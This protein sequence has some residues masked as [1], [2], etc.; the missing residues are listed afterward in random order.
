MASK[1]Y[2]IPDDC[3]YSSSDEWVR[4][5]G[6]EA[7]I[8]VTD[9][10]QD[11]LSDIVFVELPEPGTQIQAGETFG[12]VESVKAVND[13]YAPVTGEVIEVHAALAEHPEWVN[14]EPYGRGWFINVA[15]ED[16]EELDSLLSPEDYLKHVVERAGK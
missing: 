7:R 15:L 3:R 4:V 5:D 9:Y 6:T 14:E 2:E 12:V 8:G 1:T 11:E 13:L 16:L 10:A